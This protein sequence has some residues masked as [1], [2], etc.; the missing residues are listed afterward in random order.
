MFLHEG[1]N[2]LVG[3]LLDVRV[4]AILQIL[5]HVSIQEKVETCDIAEGD[6]LSEGGALFVPQRGEELEV[7]VT[8]LLL[9]D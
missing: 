7:E 1:G 3:V 9:S 5:L 4:Y 2:P 6:V 8:D